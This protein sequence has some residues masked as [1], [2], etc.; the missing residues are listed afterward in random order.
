MRFNKGPMQYSDLVS[1]ID[2]PFSVFAKHACS[3]TALYNTMYFKCKPL[4]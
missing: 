1:Q 4:L 2:L 3:K